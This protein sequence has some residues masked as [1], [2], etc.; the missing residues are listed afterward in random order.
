[1]RHWFCFVYSSAALDIW[2]EPIPQSYWERATRVTKKK[3]RVMPGEENWTCHTGQI[4]KSVVC[5]PSGCT[6]V[7][8]QGWMPWRCYP[9]APPWT[10]LEETDLDVTRTPPLYLNQGRFWCQ[11]GCSSPDTPY[12]F[13]RMP[14][15]QIQAVFSISWSSWFGYSSSCR[16]EPRTVKQDHDHGNH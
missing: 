7:Y 12:Y 4:S 10:P 15:W 1:M 6:M 16:V 9:T 13:R 5:E 2:F 14:E 3:N 11:D 8:L